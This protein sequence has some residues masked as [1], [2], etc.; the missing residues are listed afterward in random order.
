MLSVSI[1]P[2]PHDTSVISAVTA[3]LGREDLTDPSDRCENEACGA[4]QR[5]VKNTELLTWPRVLVIH[6]KRLGLW[7]VVTQQA[8]KDFRHVAFEQFLD[9][10]ADI[11][12]QLKAVIVHSSNQIGGHYTTYAHGVDQCWYYCDDST[13][14]RPTTIEEVLACSAYML[15]YQR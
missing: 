10:R 8:E 14:P 15:W 5:R 12:Y 9:P 6:L 4:L 3:H 1:P 11:R 2:P 7:N 13:A